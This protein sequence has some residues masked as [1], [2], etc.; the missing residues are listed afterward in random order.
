MILKSKKFILRNIKKSDFE[1]YAKNIIDEDI[2]KNFISSPSN[3]KQAKKDFG[4][5][6]SWKKRKNSD[7]FVIDVYGEV[8][9]VIELLEII[10]KLKAKLSYW[11][12]KRY[13]G[14]GIM[15]KAVKLASKYG[16]DKYKLRR[17]YA[18]GRI[19]N[20]ASARVLEKAGFKLEG[21]QRKNAL[22]NG[23]YYDDF[24]YAKTR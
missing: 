16:F 5:L 1:S 4:E 6:L 8:A 7:L 22:K 21:I 3:L 12:G 23:K 15:T 19:Y 10:P 24:L 17:I 2:L 13:R 11:L 20:K 14:K 18:Q 9:G